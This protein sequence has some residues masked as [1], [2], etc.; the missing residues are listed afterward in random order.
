MGER[1]VVTAIILVITL[2]LVVFMVEMFVPISA[3]ME[4]KDVCRNFLVKMEIQS[5]LDSSDYALLTERLTAIGFHD[6]SISAP[7]SAKF[8]SEMEL[9][10][11]AIFSFSSIHRLFSREE[12]GFEM[13][14][15]KIAV[16]RKVIH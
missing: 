3:N 15:I 10:I 7:L 12:K 8:G 5:G 9:H 2:F 6:I 16:A 4:F 11:T 1:V 13:E 14:Y